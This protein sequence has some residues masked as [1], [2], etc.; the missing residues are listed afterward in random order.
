M[1]NKKTD[2]ER[3][4]HM[5]NIKWIG[6]INK[7]EIEKYQKGKLDSNAIKMKMPET[8]NK[9]MVRAFPFVIPALII[10]FL[11]MYLKGHINNQIVVYKPY[12]FIGLIIGFFLSIIHELLHAIVYPKGV[13]TYIGIAKPVTFVALA[14]YPLNKERFIVMCLLPYIL[15]IVPLILFLFSPANY[16][17]LNSIIYGIAFVGM[18]SPY[19]D[20]YNVY[21]VIR[22]V[23]NGKKVQFYGDDTYYI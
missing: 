15:G 3:A 9:M 2:M 19:P 4:N 1:K 11:A 10:M 21:Q 23:P 18:V 7:N 14:S 17:A 20:A 13:N 22:Q 8:M 5:P 6:F 12:M 16:L